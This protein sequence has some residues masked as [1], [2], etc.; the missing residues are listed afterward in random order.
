[1]SKKKKV[2]QMVSIISKV[3]QLISNIQHQK[4]H[5]WSKFQ[6]ITSKNNKKVGQA[7]SKISKVAQMV[8]EFNSGSEITPLVKISSLYIKKRET[9]SNNIINIKSRSVEIKIQFGIRN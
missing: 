9:R 3:G 8:S 1:M 7:I 6:V 5:P 2:G 4:L